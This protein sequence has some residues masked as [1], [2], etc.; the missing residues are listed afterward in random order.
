MKGNEVS[1]WTRA[2]GEMLDTLPI[3]QNVL[4]LWDFFL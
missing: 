4:L 2:I 1:G 3:D